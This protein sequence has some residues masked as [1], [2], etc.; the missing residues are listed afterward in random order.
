AVSSGESWTVARPRGMIGSDNPAL[1]AAAFLSAIIS[2]RLR[3]RPA[4]AIEGV[5]TGVGVGS[6]VGLGAGV[7]AGTGQGFACSSM[8]LSLDATEASLS[9]SESPALAIGSALA[10][11]AGL[12]STVAAFVSSRLLALASSLSLSVVILSFLIFP[13]L[14]Y[15]DCFSCISEG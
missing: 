4:A 1:S 13:Y 3:F 15:L 11:G 10:M 12:A 7:G 9:L 14:V 8:L 2:A 6:C 5:A